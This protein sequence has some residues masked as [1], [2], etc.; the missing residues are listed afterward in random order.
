[1]SKKILINTLFLGNFNVS[2]EVIMKYCKLKNITVYPERGEKYTDGEPDYYTY[3]TV[4]P[5]LRPQIINY[6][7]ATDEAMNKYHAEFKEKIFDEE[8]FER[9]DPVLIEIITEI[10]IEK[11]S[12]NNCRL[13]IIEIPDN[14]EWTIN[15]NF[16][17]EWVCENI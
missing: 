17:R 11:S 14:I 13:K 15:S 1:M 12:G 16:G 6:D 5:E 3:W 7:D 2:H 4:P 8:K 9:D 10:G